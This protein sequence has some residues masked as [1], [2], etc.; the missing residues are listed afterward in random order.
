M[1]AMLV[2]IRKKVQDVLFV[3]GQ[4]CWLANGELGNSTQFAIG[5]LV[6]DGGVYAVGSLGGQNQSIQLTHAWQDVLE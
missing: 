2:S 5:I 4:D 6:R 1:G 3:S